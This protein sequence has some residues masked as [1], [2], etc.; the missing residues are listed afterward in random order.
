MGKIL[1]ERVSVGHLPDGPCGQGSWL[2][3]LTKHVPGQESTS[4]KPCQSRSVRVR[5]DAPRASPG[6]PVAAADGQHVGGAS[7][8][9]EDGEESGE[10]RFGVAEREGGGPTSS[11]PA[12]VWDKPLIVKSK[13]P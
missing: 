4:G 3:F 11:G 12:W 13:K 10:G 6:W 5:W 8:H 7:T 9:W 2:G 1:C